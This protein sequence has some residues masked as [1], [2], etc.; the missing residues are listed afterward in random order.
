MMENKREKNISRCES[1]HSSSKIN[2]HPT[3]T[4]TSPHP[5]AFIQENDFSA[6]CNKCSSLATMLHMAAMSH[7][8]TSIP[9]S[10]YEKLNK[11]TG[12]NLL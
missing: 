7:A 1:T 5:K 12:F 8:S 11:T 10:T 2:I 9:V 3:R 6:T 4:P